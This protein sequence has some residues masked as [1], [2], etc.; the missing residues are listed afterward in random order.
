M[1]PVLL[2]GGFWAKGKWIRSMNA[3]REDDLSRDSLVS[4]NSRLVSICYDVHI[5]LSVPWLFFTGLRV[6]L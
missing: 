1:I 3:V 5:K 6:A 2:I 4:V